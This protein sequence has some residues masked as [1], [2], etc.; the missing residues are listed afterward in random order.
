MTPHFKDYQWI[1]VNS[2]AG[3]DSSAA[4]DAVVVEADRQRF[5]R[6]RIVVAHATFD[7]EWPGTKE[8]AAEHAAHYG[9]RFECYERPQG[10]LLDMVMKRG[11][12]PSNKQR[13]CTSE[14]KRGQIAKLFTK[15]TKETRDGAAQNAV[16]QGKGTLRQAVGANVDRRVEDHDDDQ[17]VGGVRDQGHHDAHEAL[18]Q[19]RADRHPGA[20]DGRTAKVRFLSVFGFRAEESPARRKKPVFQ[21]D[22]RLTN[23]KRHVDVWLPIHHLTTDEVWRRIAVAGLRSHWAYA[24]GMSRLSCVWCIFAPDRQLILAARQP[25][26]RP[27]VERYVQV[28]VKTGH[29]FR[30]KTDLVEI[31]KQADDPTV[32]VTP[33]VDDGCWNM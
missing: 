3:K 15:L 14:L 26:V 25:E 1:V 30:V 31:L 21:A 19:G 28:Q 11:K 6:S 18:P 16:L 7:A 23:S 29:K 24:R 13:Y 8:L 27:L 32:N 9:L 10:G 4:L 12:W 20:G 17:R 22:K 5:P 33:G 2:S